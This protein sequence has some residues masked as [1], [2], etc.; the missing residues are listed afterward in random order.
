[1]TSK[2]E[3]RNIT[4]LKTSCLKYVFVY[5][6]NEYFNHDNCKKRDEKNT[7]A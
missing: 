6:I 3:R 2:K 1:M 5:K 7:L 4:L